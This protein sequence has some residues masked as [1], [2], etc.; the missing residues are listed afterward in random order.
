[1]KGDSRSGRQLE[2][3]RN[4]EKSDSSSSGAISERFEVRLRK[5][6]GGVKIGI[7]HPSSLCGWATQKSWGTKARS[8]SLNSEALPPVGLGTPE[9]FCHRLQTSSATV[10]DSTVGLVVVGVVVGIVHA[11]SAVD[12][13]AHRFLLTRFEVGRRKDCERLKENSALVQRMFFAEDIVD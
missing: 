11:I 3:Q 5:D 10:E 4:R 12:R 8:A 13:R 6:G 2:G 7:V 1:M 9:F